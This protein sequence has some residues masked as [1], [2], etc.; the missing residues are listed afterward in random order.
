[1]LFNGELKGIFSDV[2]HMS[3]K[4]A[5]YINIDEKASAIHALISNERPKIKQLKAPRNIAR[6]DWHSNHSKTT[7]CE[8]IITINISN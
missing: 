1:M 8:G 7:I 3:R 5:I 4:M 6:S 2:T